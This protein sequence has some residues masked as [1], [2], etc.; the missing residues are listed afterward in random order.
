MSNSR[1]LP[2]SAIEVPGMRIPSEGLR[3]M[4]HSVQQTARGVSRLRLA[5]MFSVGVASVWF[6]L[7][8]VGCTPSP[9]LKYDREA[10]P[11]VL[12]PIGYAGIS[13][14]RARF[15][16]I[17]CAIQQDH[18]SRFPDDRP[19]DQALHRLSGEAPP[20]AKPVYLG[21]ARLPMRLV[22]IPGL[23]EECVADF[24]QPF[25]DSRSHLE[26]LG[27]KTDF[28]MVS[29]LGG[30][31]RNA[32]QIREA[33]A[34]MPMI[35]DERLVFIGYSKG[36]TDVLE[37][38]VRYPELSSRT[39][40]VVTLAGVVSG[41]PIA[42]DVPEVLKKFADQVFEGKCPPGEGLAFESLSRKERL[43]W[44]SA[45]RLPNTVRYYS[46]AAFTDRE[47]ISLLLR[48]SYDKLSLVDPLNDSQV[49]FHD[50]LVPGGVLLGYLNAD[51]WAVAM[52]FN[53]VHPTLAAAF[54]TRNAFP[55]EVLL[56]AI[57][58]FVEE[59]LLAQ[60]NR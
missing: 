12:V 23:S 24:I 26:S 27:F 21:K 1:L 35:A 41:T 34:G 36:A 50:A 44:L 32:S 59:S 5:R 13:D 52:P 56:E 49:V 10:S 15:R 45:N 4:R 37:A 29:G 46:L 17:F 55:R 51:H 60:P 25:S 9:M 16:E 54:V 11:T 48:P 3:R 8:W 18:G 28:I 6:S 53:R 20:G 38:M 42:D 7:F 47:N 58:R 39:A 2:S 57:A 30:S 40:A 22:V 33:V 31:A 19:C 43:A 14:E